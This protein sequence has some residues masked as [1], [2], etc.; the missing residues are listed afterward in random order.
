MTDWKN[1]SAGYLTNQLARLFERGLSARIR[2]LG[3]T[4]GA[5]PALVEL[6]EREGLTQ[7][8]LVERLDIEQATMANTLARMQRDGLIA[9][10]RS[11]ADGRVQEIR[12]TDLGNSLRAP[13]IAAAETVNDTALSGLSSDERDQFLTLVSKIIQTF[14]EGEGASPGDDSTQQT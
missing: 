10:Q 7:K 14:D 3:L 6:W 5:F 11:K 2:P 9:R 1:R 12:L 4:T 13:A 8:E